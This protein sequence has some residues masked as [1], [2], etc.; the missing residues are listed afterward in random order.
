MITSSRNEEGALNTSMM[1][2]NSQ[3][4]IFNN[5]E[6]IISAIDKLQGFQKKIDSGTILDGEIKLSKKKQKLATKESQK[7]S[8]LKK[9]S[10]NEDL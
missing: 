4:L 8:S 9:Q 10:P 6:E 3:D 5:Q 7:S 2:Y 1:N